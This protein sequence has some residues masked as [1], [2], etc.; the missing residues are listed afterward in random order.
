MEE[1]LEFGTVRDL[2]C[3]VASITGFDVAVLRLSVGL[4]VNSEVVSLLWSCRTSEEAVTLLIT[5]LVSEVICVTYMAS[6]FSVLRSL[7]STV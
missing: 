2:K 3:V 1:K 7:V 4:C 5:C 6:C